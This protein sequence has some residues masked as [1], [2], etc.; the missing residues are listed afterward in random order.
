MAR[1][2]D[3]DSATSQFYINTVD[4]PGLDKGKYCAFGRVIDGMDVVDKIRNVETTSKG[5]HE[6]VPSEAIVI[7]KAYRADKK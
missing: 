2:N 5:P 1:T 3:L 6:N 7:K 4:N